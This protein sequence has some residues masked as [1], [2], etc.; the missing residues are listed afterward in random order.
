MTDNVV[1]YL[2]SVVKHKN[3]NE[4]RRV[5]RITCPEFDIEIVGVEGCVRKMASILVEK[6]CQ[7]SRGYAVYRGDTLVF[8]VVPLNSWVNGE[9]R[10]PPQFRKGN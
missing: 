6:N 10:R 4:H 2:D 1:C 3:V 8:N 9:D 7:I 5:P